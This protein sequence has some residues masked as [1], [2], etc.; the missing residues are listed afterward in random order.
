[1]EISCPKPP[2]SCQIVRNIASLGF[3][4]CL[5]LKGA[6]G[7]TKSGPPPS[8]LA[9]SAKCADAAYKH[10][11][12]SLS[13]YNFAVREIC[14]AMEMETTAQFVS[15][16]K[17]LGVAFDS[18][19]VG[20]PLHHVEIVRPSQE[21]N[22]A[23]TFR[24][25]PRVVRVIFMAE[26]HRGSPMADSLIGFMGNSLTRLDPM[27]EYGFGRLARENREVMTPQA[28]IFYPNGRFSAVR[29]L[30]PENPALIA[31]SELPIE[32]PYHS[33]IGQ[34]HPGQKEA[35]SDGVVP[36]LEQPSLW[37]AIR[38]DRSERARSF[39][40]PRRGARDDSDSSSE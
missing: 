4:A 11:P 28:A 17:A 1:M 19:K 12:G 20:L 34:H 33:V 8:S 30:S 6:G 40:Q 36:L 37:S 26:P 7:A 18:P 3:V 21:L 35:G 14:A 24:R 16:L 38:G 22:R 5:L 23:L 9:A 32:V 2:W 29:T 39:N 27:L 13:A 15:S 10:L 31:L 25:N